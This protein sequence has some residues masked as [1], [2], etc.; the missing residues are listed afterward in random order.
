LDGSQLPPRYKITAPWI[1]HLN[2]NDIAPA[3][4]NLQIN[5]R[6]EAFVPWIFFLGSQTV[7]EVVTTNVIH[8]FGD[9]SAPLVFHR[10]D[11]IHIYSSRRCILRTIFAYF[12]C[13]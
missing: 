3:V 1:F 4:I 7:E 6:I 8:R 5:F 10:F 12:D 9:C 13:N 11:L 2:S